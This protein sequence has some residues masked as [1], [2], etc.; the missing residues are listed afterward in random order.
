MKLLGTNYV[1][2]MVLGT[3]NTKLKKNCKWTKFNFDF[4]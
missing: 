2:P 1:L 4:F 3:E